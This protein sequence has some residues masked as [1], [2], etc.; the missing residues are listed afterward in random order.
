MK[1]TVII[2]FVIASYIFVFRSGYEMGYTDMYIDH[3]EEKIET[4]TAVN[5]LFK[6]LTEYEKENH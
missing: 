1:Y 5:L 2:I 3:V 6:V 4:E